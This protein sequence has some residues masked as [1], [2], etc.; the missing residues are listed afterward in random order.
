M[1]FNCVH[2]PFTSSQHTHTKHSHFIGTHTVAHQL[3]CTP[4]A[5]TYTHIRRV[6]SGRKRVLRAQTSSHNTCL[7]I[8]TYS[9]PHTHR[10]P[11]YPWVGE[12]ALS[13]CTTHVH[14]QTHTHTHKHAQTHAHTQTVP[15][16]GENALSTCTM[17][18]PACSK[19]SRPGRCERAIYIYRYIHMNMYIQIHI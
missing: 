2:T 12:K 6:L 17:S 13:T 8:Y 18:L 19:G 14:T 10:H 15:S 16:G 5:Y 1:C 4:H 7:Y 11:R 3:T 9:D